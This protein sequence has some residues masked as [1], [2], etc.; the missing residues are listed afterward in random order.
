VLWSPYAIWNLI[1]IIVFLYFFRMERTV[2]SCF[3]I[4]SYW[5]GGLLGAG[6]IGHWVRQTDCRRHS[7]NRWVYDLCPSPSIITSRKR[8]GSWFCSHPEVMGGRHLLNWLNC[9]RKVF[10][11]LNNVTLMVK[12]TNT[13]R[14]V[15]HHVHNLK[16]N[17]PTF[18][19]NIL[20][21]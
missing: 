1:V 5:E 10:P 16:P 18:S 14:P 6:E 19:F 7:Q 17:L 20:P 11:K 15:L 3:L 21:N 8:F 4:C 12:I 13:K 9:V 2:C